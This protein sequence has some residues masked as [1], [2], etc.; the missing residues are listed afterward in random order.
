MEAS[1][2]KDA[3]YECSLYG[4][5]SNGDYERVRELVIAL[6]GEDFIEIRHHELVLFPTITTP[7]GPSRNDDLALRLRNGYINRY[8][9]ARSNKWQLYMQGKPDSRP[10]RSVTVRPVIYTR[11]VG[12]FSKF[13]LALGYTNEYETAKEG[14]CY[15][16]NNSVTISIY[17]LYKVGKRFDMST[18]FNIDGNDSWVMEVS[19]VPGPVESIPSSVETLDSIQDYLKDT[20]HIQYVDHLIL[21]NRI[22]YRNTE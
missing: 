10:D 20:I 18:L 3:L 1:L 5:F 9:K 14:F 22:S 6:C 4:L 19:S 16:F 12:N 8:S 13:F 7:V 21:E 17:K 2:D 15:F 11:I